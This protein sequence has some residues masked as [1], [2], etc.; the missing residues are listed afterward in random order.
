[1]RCCFTS[2]DAERICSQIARL[3]RGL[4]L[5]IL[6]IVFLRILRDGNGFDLPKR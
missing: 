4:W 6:Y 5:F 1:M 2:V 3:Q